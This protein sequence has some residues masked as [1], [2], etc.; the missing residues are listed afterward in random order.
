MRDFEFVKVIVRMPNG[1]TLTTT[2]QHVL[3]RGKF[4]HFKRNDLEPQIFLPL[5]EFGLEKAQEAE[6]LERRKWDQEEAESIQMNLELET[7]E[8]PVATE[9]SDA[10]V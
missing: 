6:E 10:V 1:K 3:R 5:S 4:L 7:P 9:V 8:H 2:R